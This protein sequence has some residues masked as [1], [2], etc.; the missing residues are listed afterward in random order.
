MGSG[1]ASGSSIPGVSLAR[2]IYFRGGQ[3]GLKR[4][5]GAERCAWHPTGSIAGTSTVVFHIPPDRLPPHAGAFEVRVHRRN[6]YR[7]EARAAVRFVARST[8]SAWR[9]VFFFVSLAIV[10][11]SQRALGGGR[12][13][14][15]TDPATHADPIDDWAVRTTAGAN[16]WFHRHP[17]AADAAQA[18]CSA[19][20]D[21]STIAL[22]LCG[23]LFRP[24]VRPVLAMLLFTALLCAGQLAATVPCAAGFLRPR[25]GALLGVPVP[26]LFADPRAAESGIL[27]G[28]AGTSMCVAIQFWELG[29]LRAAAAQAGALPLV[30]AL[31]VAFRANRGIDVLA[32][33]FAAIAACSVAER[34][35][36]TFDRLLLVASADGMIWTRSE[37]RK[38]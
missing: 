10:V 15:R 4:V 21:A 23:A 14:A 26:A 30:A 12:G 22:L 2:W 29:Y 18:L 19:F 28:L 7:V 38:E 6:G 36:D 35:A 25:G 5:A 8:S 31:V 13:C 16:S 11:A 32:T 24:T 9:W 37:K 17:A 1:S 3:A 34:L 33:A 20:V 27:S